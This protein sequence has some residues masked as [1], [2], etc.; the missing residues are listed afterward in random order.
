MLVHTPNPDAPDIRRAGG[1]VPSSGSPET[2]DRTE[3]DVDALNTLRAVLV[4]FTAIAAVMLVFRG[5]WFPAGVLG[6]GILAHMVLFAYL[7]AQRRRDAE[8][9]PFRELLGH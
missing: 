6:A 3:P 7:R 1:S 9:D 5:E 2:L 4:G 8:Q